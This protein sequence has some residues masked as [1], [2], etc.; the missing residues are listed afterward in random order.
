MT[1]QK[2]GMIFCLDLETLRAAPAYG[3]VIILG[4]CSYVVLPHP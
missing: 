4:Y 3:W 2:G 1:I